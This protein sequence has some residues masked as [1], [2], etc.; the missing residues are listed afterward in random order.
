M[1]V[2]RSTY[3]KHFN[4]RQTPRNIENQELRSNILSI[5]SRS[6]KRLGAYKIRQRLIVEQGKKVSVGRIY[7]MMKSMSL[8][9]MSTVKPVVSGKKVEESD[10][11]NLLKQKFN[12]KKPNL[13]WVSDITYV[14]VAGKFC[15]VCVIIDLY[16]RKVIA[17]KTSTKIDTK[18]VLDTFAAACLKR[19]NPKGVMFHS[20]RGCQY[21][22]ADFRK[23]L[24]NAEFVQSFSA[25]GHPYDNAVAES[26]F[27]YLKKEELNRRCFNSLNELNLS[28]FE[29][30]ESFYNKSR[31]HSAN[32]FLSPDEKELIFFCS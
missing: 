1:N 29:Y 22:S 30:I 11:E 24:D 3:Y 32:D 9:K 20:D 19:K 28:L 10:C 5:Y 21:T 18:L 27:K 12:P 25:K 7:R 31:P 26:F 6:K 23:A 4:E 14:R 13:V 17:Y 16:A 15:Y 2:N 8:P